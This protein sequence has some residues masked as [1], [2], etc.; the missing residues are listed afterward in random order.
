MG[1]LA[2]R[3]N[4]GDEREAGGLRHGRG[5]QAAKAR[6]K[7]TAGRL[8]WRR[9]SRAGSARSDPQRDLA[10][11]QGGRDQLPA[12]AALAG[13]FLERAQFVLLVPG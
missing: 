13:E 1:A 9:G 4:Q 5:P 12:Q 11:E 7:H 6:L 3:G 10:A 2:M 8:P